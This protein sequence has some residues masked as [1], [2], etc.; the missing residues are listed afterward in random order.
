MVINMRRI[1]KLPPAERAELFDIAAA[2]M[3]I[4]SGLIEKDFW[5]CYVLD[6]LFHKLAFKNG[7]SFKGGTC[8]SK[9]FGLIERFSED[10]D[11]VMDWRLLGYTETEPWNDRSNTAQE[12]FKQDSIARTNA[13]LKDRFIPELI[14]T[15]CI[16]TEL[17][18]DIS[19]ADE[20][21]TVLFKYPKIHS[22]PAVLDVIRLEIGPMA[23]WTPANNVTIQ[24]YL[25]ECIPG[26][27]DSPKVV[28]RAVSPNRTFWEKVSIL[29][30]ESNRSESKKMPAGYSRHYYDV[31]KLG[32]SPV[33]TN[34]LDN[35]D[36]LRK[37]LDFKMKFYRT[38]W[39]KFEEAIPGSIC[40]L[41]PDY[42]IPEIAKDYEIMQEMLFGDRPQFHEIHEYLQLLEEELNS[43]RN[44]T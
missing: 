13:F 17:E 30:Q 42:R 43:K 25:S 19:L 6:V 7:F 8:L 16:D 37:V 41:P 32:Q 4:P 34:A 24:S 27:I 3:K 31:Y 14:K 38:P 5:V 21:E 29:H 15:I 18:A 9:A 44:I 23:A 26:V 36:L 28:I 2:K 22:L 40:L 11:L 10:I 20:A 33:K 35:L 39:A 1:I 12:K